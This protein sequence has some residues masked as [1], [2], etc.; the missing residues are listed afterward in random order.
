MTT[1]PQSGRLAMPATAS[2]FHLGIFS[3]ITSR[4]GLLNLGATALNQE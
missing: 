1:I 2:N 4:S 3:Y